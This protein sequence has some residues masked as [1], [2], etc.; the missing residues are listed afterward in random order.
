MIT[1][2]HDTGSQVF[3]AWKFP[4]VVVE[5]RPEPC[6]VL[7][8]DLLFGAAHDILQHAEKQD[9]DT[10][11]CHLNRRSGAA[12][13]FQRCRLQVSFMTS[14]TSL[15]RLLARLEA[16]KRQF[17]AAEQRDLPR[18]IETLGSRR[19][20]DAQSLIRLHEALLFFRAYPPKARVL[21]LTEEL[22]DTFAARL[23]RLRR[24][25][26]DLEPFEEPDV[27][28]IAGTAFSAIFSYDIAR[29]LA[30][31]YAR[32]IEIDW[33]AT[34]PALLGPLLSKLN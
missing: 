31:H 4:G 8:L 24:S 25:G 9:L 2:Q 13:W 5:N 23:D 3:Q 21:R 34:D 10:H 30:Q 26:D 32:D 27:S 16:A 29:W 17:G 18:L 15:D 6:P 28:G 22:L 33:D 19:F 7:Q 20:P 12:Q 1:S 14:S 11:L